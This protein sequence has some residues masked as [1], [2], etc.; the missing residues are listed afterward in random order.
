GDIHVP[1]GQ[2]DRLTVTGEKIEDTDAPQADP[3]SAAIDQRIETVLER[4]VPERHETRYDELVVDSGTKTLTQDTYI[5]DDVIVTEE[6]TV[7]I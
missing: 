3:V 6:G 2:S 5:E 4:D 1:P 7:E